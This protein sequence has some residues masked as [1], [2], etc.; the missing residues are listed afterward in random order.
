M[1]NFYCQVFFMGQE[2]D[3]LNLGLVFQAQE[4]KSFQRK[5]T[6][7]CRKLDFWGCFSGV[8]SGLYEG[9][10]ESEGILWLTR[11]WY[12]VGEKRDW[13]GKKRDPVGRLCC[14]FLSVIPWLWQSSRL[15]KQIKAK[16]ALSWVSQPAFSVEGKSLTPEVWFFW[17]SGCLGEAVLHASRKMGTV[18]CIL[19][20]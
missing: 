2:E 5:L 13:K 14:L 12:L 18:F 19:L 10:H 8:L 16:L 6:Y 4:K 11:S 15:L 7:H 9:F 1:Q 17:R 20:N 3:N